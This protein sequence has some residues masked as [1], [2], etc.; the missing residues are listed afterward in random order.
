[1]LTATEDRLDKKAYFTNKRLYT[2]L[3]TTKVFILFFTCFLQIAWIPEASICHI[4]QTFWSVLLH[5]I[6]QKMSYRQIPVHTGHQ[7][8]HVEPGNRDLDKVHQRGKI[9]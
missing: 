8:H 4:F 3:L 1:M 6:Y 9:L 7:C 5:E 2:I